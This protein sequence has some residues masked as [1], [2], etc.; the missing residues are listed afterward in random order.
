MKKKQSAKRSGPKK[1]EK[2]D[3]LEAVQADEKQ[4]AELSEDANDG[5]TKGV[6]ED[7]TK[8]SEE[9]VPELA[10][11]SAQRPHSTSISHQSKMRSSSFRS[12]SGPL[13][14]PGYPPE[15]NTAPDI[16][17]K[18]AVRI[19]ELEKENKRLAREAGDSERRWK[20][21]EEELEDLREAEGDSSSKG[22]EVSSTS[23]F[24]NDVEKLVCFQIGSFLSY[25]SYALP[26][27]NRS[28]CSPTPKLPTSSSSV[29]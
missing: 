26:L 10:T 23:R 8:A 18:Q 12:S 21:A 27:E 2:A 24:S 14:S 1:D 25:G 29:S 4:G 11:T 17:R 15:E 28:R 19:E 22:Q 3:T 6:E 5:D 20:K 9:T 7:D 16:Y 13:G